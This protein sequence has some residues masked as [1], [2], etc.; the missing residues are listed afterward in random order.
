[1]TQSARVLIGWELGDGSDAVAVFAPVAEELAKRGLS[2]VL[3]LRDVA[4]LPAGTPFPVVTAP[5]AAPLVA[6]PRPLAGL[7]EFLGLN[8]FADVES[9]TPVVHAWRSLI[10]LV[11]PALLVAVLAPGLVLANGGERPVVQLGID[12]FSLPPPT[13]PFLPVW[14]P[15]IP[16]LYG[17]D[18]VFAAM[19]GTQRRLGLPAPEAA[20]ALF[21]GAAAALAVLPEFDPLGDIREPSAAGPFFRLPAPSDT[22]PAALLVEL[23]CRSPFFGLAVDAAAMTGLPVRLFAAGAPPE[24]RAALRASGLDVLASPPTPDGLAGAAV[25]HDGRTA[26]AHAALAAGAPQ[27]VVPSVSHVRRFNASLLRR[28]GV[29]VELPECGDARTTAT[30]IRDTLGDNGIRQ[31]AGAAARLM[32]ERCDGEAA[33]RVADIC[34]ELARRRR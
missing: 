34:A 5:A 11:D 15:L 23:S 31:R 4:M 10:E 12:G 9:L 22:P 27:L 25:L 7:A 8:G 18:D 28:L 29:A 33:A 13:L 16:T 24:M 14:E 2:P 26:L 1:V 21:A 32:H 3:A 6:L 17:E 19:L 30:A 20:A